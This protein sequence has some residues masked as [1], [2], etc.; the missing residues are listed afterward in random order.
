MYLLLHRWDNC[1]PDKSSSDTLLINAKIEWTKNFRQTCIYVNAAITGHFE[2]VF[3]ENLGR[4]ITC[5]NIIL[6]S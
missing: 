6:T 3:E 5:L 1:G 2:F 4:E